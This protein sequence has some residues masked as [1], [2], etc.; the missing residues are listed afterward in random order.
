MTRWGG[1]LLAATF[2]AACGS[3]GSDAPATAAELAFDASTT[4]RKAANVQTFGEALDGTLTEQESQLEVVLERLTALEADREAL[5]ARVATLEVENDALTKRVGTLE[6]EE[7]AIVS[8]LG[9]E[10]TGAT[11]PA[12]TVLAT[13]ERLHTQLTALSTMPATLEELSN[14]VAYIETGVQALSDCPPGTTAVGEFCVESTPRALDNWGNAVIYCGESGGHVCT[15]DE[16]SF[17]CQNPPALAGGVGLPELT[18]ELVNG[19]GG[20]AGA[21]MLFDKGECG[22]AGD[23][24]DGGTDHPYRCCYRRIAPGAGPPVPPPG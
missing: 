24:V 11:L 16:Y 2:M 20:Y 6:S 1:F 14:R 21:A 9:T 10:V 5:A 3:S 23:P 8:V 18:S 7:P 19:L 12:G 13:L 4:A 17:A 15:A 22:L